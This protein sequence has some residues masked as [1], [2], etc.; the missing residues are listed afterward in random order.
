MIIIQASRILSLAHF[1]L[2]Y[3]RERDDFGNAIKMPPCLAAT[4]SF[5]ATGS[6]CDWQML[7]ALDQLTVQAAE[8]VGQRHG[9]GWHDLL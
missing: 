4:T 1:T 8:R 7:E 5:D 6:I 3:Q 2:A 9:F